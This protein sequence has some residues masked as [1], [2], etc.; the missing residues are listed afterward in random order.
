MYT[1][2]KTTKACFQEWCCSP[3]PPPTPWTA[4]V[5]ADSSN[6]PGT[7]STPEWDAYVA[8]GG[9]DQSTESDPLQGICY[10]SEARPNPPRTLTPASS[11]TSAIDG[12][13]SSQ[14]SN[15]V[16]VPAPNNNNKPGVVGNGNG[17]TPTG[18]GSMTDSAREQQA[19]QKK[20]KRVVVGTTV[21]ILLLLALLLTMVGW[22]L[23]RRR[24]E[25]LL[26]AM[27]RKF[28]K[29]D[30][31]DAAA[32]DDF[33]DDDDVE[34]PTPSSTT[35]SLENPG[36]GNDSGSVSYTPSVELVHEPR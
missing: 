9:N 27:N 28:N 31:D 35:G 2:K 4:E 14:N 32:A 5:P 20:K 18:L 19:L 36:S 6:P 8:E 25:L 15:E 11:P 33:D 26:C 13:G 3:C 22:S 7:F 1:T 24:R 16:P 29:M 12:V 10:N 34:D 30:D 21:S 17:S 23:Y